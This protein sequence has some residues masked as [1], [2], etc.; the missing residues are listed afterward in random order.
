MLSRRSTMAGASARAQARVSS[1]LWGAP[2][3]MVCVLLLWLGGIP[4]VGAQSVF[5]CADGQGGHSYQS[6]PCAQG[7]PLRTWAADSQPVVSAAPAAANVVKPAPVQ[8]ATTVGGRRAA[9]RRVSGTRGND[10]Q[11][12]CTAARADREAALR[13]LGTQRRYDDLRRLNDR[14]SAVCNHRGQ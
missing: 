6:Q 14:V 2:M 13:K 1:S 8:R 11:A 12:R 3:R 4:M 7:E 5:K 10:Q 9:S